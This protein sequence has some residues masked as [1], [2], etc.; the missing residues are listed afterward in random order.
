LKADRTRTGSRRER[1][2]APHEPSR[3]VVVLLLALSALGLASPVSL[4]NAIEPNAP[5]RP[6][7][8]EYQEHALRNEGNAERGRSIFNGQTTACFQCHS[9]DGK[10]DKVGPD[11]YAAGNKYSRADLIR[12]VLEPSSTIMM[13]FSTTVVETT[14]GERIEGV[15]KA[16]SETEL[17]LAGI[18]SVTQRVARA[19]V[20]EQKTSPVSLM[21]EGL[22]A[23]LSLE[24]FTDLIAYLESLKQPEMQLANAAG[25][26][27]VIER[28]SRPVGVIPFHS[29]TNRF[30]R[31]IWFEEHPVL[32]GRFLVAE[33]M[34]AKLW[35]LDKRGKAESKTLFADV[36]GEVFVTETEGL[37]GVTFHPRFRKNRKYYLMHE[38]MD[39]GRRAMVIAE[40][41]ARKD[42]RQ[43][44]G[45]PSRR[46]LKIDV[47]T[48]VHH[49][50]GIVFGPDGYLYIGMGDAGPQTDPL[51]HSQDLHSFAGKLLRID[52]DRAEAGRAFAIP[53]DNP[54]VQHADPEVRPEI[55]AYGLR[56]P[57]RFSFDPK[58]RDLWVADVGQDRFEEVGIVRAGENHGWNVYEG[59]GLF[60]TVYRKER[61]K[62]IPPVI[63]F[64]RMHGA[65]ITA[66]YVYRARRG[67]SFDGVY[68]CGDYES[69][70]L[71]GVTQRN[72]GLRAIREIG[73]SPAKVVAF[74]RD[75][76][77]E[78]YVVGYDLGMI[79]K[80]DFQQ[81]KFE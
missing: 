59:F 3:R 63:S 14:A 41:V 22:Q 21:P 1:I 70:R 77:G 25:T 43:D 75:R 72:R 79:Y 65:S 34:A 16:V 13:G 56:Q 61:E 49:G 62:Y 40:R 80:L 4:S 28:L 45:G 52:V 9:A 68:I 17:L 35:L 60:S 55:W 44:A 39:Q 30:E 54:F 10:A 24:E 53:S 69:K 58:T 5:A 46:I 29:E 23:V 47:E 2:R 71:W 51:G 38:F 66:G 50:G 57:W 81:A 76:R 7:S 78:L 48:E 11:L 42:L 15:L 73:T 6:L 31:P 26:P 20:R 8:R 19:S 12:S 18:G 74:G 33:Q 67:S 37:L 64:R 36:R 32:D 27:A